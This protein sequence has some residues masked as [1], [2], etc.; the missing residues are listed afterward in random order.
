[1][2]VRTA[3]RCDTARAPFQAFLRDNVF[4]MAGQE[5]SP[6][7]LTFFIEMREFFPLI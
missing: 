5:D 7:G 6:T 3:R 4:E 2:P 1:M